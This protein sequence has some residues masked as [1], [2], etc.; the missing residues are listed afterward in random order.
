MKKLVPLIVLVSA[1]GLLLS[2]PKAYPANDEAEIRQWLDR[3]VAAFRVHDVNAIMAM[4]TPDVV[5]Y[6]VV[7]PLQ[8]VGADAYRKDYE[9]FL[10]QYNG[11]IQVEDR[12]AKIVVSNDVAFAYGLERVKGTLKNGKSSDLW[13]RFTVG[14]RKINGKWLDIHDHVS[15]PADLETGKAVLDLKP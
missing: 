11:P 8:Y 5:A 4:Y 7:P 2:T 15:V 3:W 6:D 13:V 10:A 9:E 1:F 14:L 12:V